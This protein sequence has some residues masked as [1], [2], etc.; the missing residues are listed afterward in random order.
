MAAKCKVWPRCDCLQQGYK[1]L[2]ERNE[3]GKMPRAAKRKRN[4][5]AS[6]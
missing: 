5:K 2:R 3:C 6:R 4:V 1:N